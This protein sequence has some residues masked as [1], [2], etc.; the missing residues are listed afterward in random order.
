MR[1]SIG[2]TAALALALSAVA[3]ASHA[4]FIIDPSPSGTIAVNLN[5]V[6][7]K[8]AT[9]TDFGTVLTA[10]DVAITV[11]TPSTFASGAATIKANTG[12]LTTLTFTPVNPNAFSDF[13]FRGQDLAANQVI[14]VTVQD[15]QGGA[16]QTFM[17]TEGVANQ[18]FTRDGIISLDGETIK[19]VTISNSGGFKEAK[20]FAFSPAIVPEP[21][22]WGMMVLGSGLAG[23]ALRRRRVATT[24]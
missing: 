14:D 13:S 5:E 12:T 23:A 9:T 21:A 11:N 7:K 19:S 24:L 20:Q 1:M 8:N 6:S 16:A 4:T 10:N 15:N 22:T 2:T 3:T 18:D 17:F